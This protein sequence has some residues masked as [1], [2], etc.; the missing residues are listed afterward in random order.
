MTILYFQLLFYF[1]K[2]NVDKASNEYEESMHVSWMLSKYDIFTVSWGCRKGKHCISNYSLQS[3]TT[4]HT[5][6]S[7]ILVDW[8]FRFTT[9]L[10]FQ[11]LLNLFIPFPNKLLS[12]PYQLK[13]RTYIYDNLWPASR[14]AIGQETETNGAVIDANEIIQISFWN[15]QNLCSDKPWTCP[16]SNQSCWM[17]FNII[18][19]F[20]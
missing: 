7:F 16:I 20:I 18:Y 13:K 5:V 15:F 11:S 4:L 9:Y 3:D 1:K 14:F 8:H 19:L 17:L 12:R 6:S 2:F 10:S